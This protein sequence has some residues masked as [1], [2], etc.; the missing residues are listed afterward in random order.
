MGP[1][2]FTIARRTA[3]DVHRRERRPTRGDHEAEADRPVDGPDLEQAWIRWEVRRGLDRLAPAE[4]RILQL[5]YLEGL[6]Q[7]ETAERLGLPLGTVKS[8]SVRA[9]RSLAAVLHHLSPDSER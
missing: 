4:R 3:I 5:L 7:A 9:K 8:R 2:L 1:W 6:T